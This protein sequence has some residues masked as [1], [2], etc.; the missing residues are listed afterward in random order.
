MAIVIECFACERS[1]KIRDMLPK[2]LKVDG[3]YHCPF[4]AS[5]RM[6]IKE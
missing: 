3:V 6:K 1:F 5:I 4:C 2:K